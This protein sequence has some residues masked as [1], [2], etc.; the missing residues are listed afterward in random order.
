[1]EE[2][3]AAGKAAAVG[4]S[5]ATAVD[6]EKLRKTAKVS[7]ALWVGG[8]FVCVRARVHVSGRS[9]DL[10]PPDQI[11]VIV[12]TRGSRCDRAAEASIARAT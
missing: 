12:W 10:G 8:V 4:V 3:L 5:H 7:L 11:L 9:R 2:F 6:L 1:M